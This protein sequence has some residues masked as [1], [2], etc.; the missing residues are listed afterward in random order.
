MY[1]MPAEKMPRR[2]IPTFRRSRENSHHNKSLI[3][4][5]SG[6]PAENTTL[7]RIDKGKNPLLAS[8]FFNQL[9]FQNSG[10]LLRH[11]HL[12]MSRYLG[13]IQAAR[14]I[15]EYFV[16]NRENVRILDVAAGTGKVGQELRHLGFRNLDALDPSEG[17]LKKA[18]ERGVYNQ[19]F[20]L[21]FEMNLP[22]PDDSYDCL[23]VVGGMG[24][25]HLPAESVHEMIRLVKPGGL[26]CIAMREEYLQYVE[27]Y[28]DKLQPL[29]ENL[30]REGKWHQHKKEYVPNYAFGKDGTVF[31]YV[32][33]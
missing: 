12:G 16:S 5:H 13:P 15:G 9:R 4:I 17:M 24:E 31:Q 14:A 29:M 10:L 6:A 26:V 7:Y 33:H 25:G 28:K 1:V 8:R 18:K 19:T 2:T 22:I 20:Q 27:A 21:Y 32:I 3:T 23:V 30:E 11:T